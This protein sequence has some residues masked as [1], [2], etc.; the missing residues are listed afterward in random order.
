VIDN[1]LDNTPQFKNFEEKKGVFGTFVKDFQGEQVIK[2][3]L[4]IFR[5]VR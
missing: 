5:R 1:E 2:Y 3:K 4:L